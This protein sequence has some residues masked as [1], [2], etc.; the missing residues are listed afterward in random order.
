MSA[1]TEGSALA[2]VPD[3]RRRKSSADGRWPPPP[4]LRMRFEVEVLDGPEGAR[5]RRAQ[6][7]VIQEVLEWIA[8]QNPS[9]PGSNAPA[10][11]QYRQEKKAD[12]H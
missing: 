12:R 1:T 9:E 3:R 10:E 5:L 4:Q 7:S 6:A 8:A 11:Q 2:E